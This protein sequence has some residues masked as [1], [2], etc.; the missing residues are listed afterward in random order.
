MRKISPTPIA[1]PSLELGLAS[2]S[3]IQLFAKNGQVDYSSGLWPYE[4]EVNKIGATEVCLQYEAFTRDID[5]L[6]QSTGVDKIIFV[7]MESFLSDYMC[8]S[9][10]N[11]YKIVMIPNSQ[12]VDV[13]RIKMNYGDNVIIT[14][15][16][17]A[18]EW[19]TVNTLIV[20]PTF[21]LM[22]NTLYGYS[23]PRRFLGSDV[24]KYSFRTIAVEL[25]PAIQLDYRTS[26]Y[27]PELRELSLIDL[28]LFNKILTFKN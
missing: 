4:E 11:K 8:E 6:L 28:D 9:Y 24:V 2:S 14:N 10:G 19:V 5:H 27:S 23:Y 18:C 17:N 15:P 12:S 20:V 21:S 3:I 25:L 13:E 22:D 7:G 16:F 1:N 26:P